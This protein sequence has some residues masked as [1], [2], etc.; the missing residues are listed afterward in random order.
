ML[1]AILYGL[2]RSFDAGRQ[3]VSINRTS[4]IGPRQRFLMGSSENRQIAGLTLA[5]ASHET[6]RSIILN[7]A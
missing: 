4:S 1:K 3:F 5:D 6:G 2:G 7:G